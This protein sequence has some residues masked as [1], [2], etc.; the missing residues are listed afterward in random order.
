MVNN[1]QLVSIDLKPESIRDIENFVDTV[2]DQLFINETYYGNILM[3]LSELFNY[4]LDRKYTEAI[5][6]TYN[7]DYKSI[8]IS[9]Q[10]IDNQSI[11]K[12]S[13]A[14]DFE[15]IMHNDEDKN[16]FLI[17]SLVD[18]ISILDKNTLLFEFDISAMHNEIYKQRS[19]LLLNYFKK[20][21][22]AEKVRKEND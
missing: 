7:S 5:Y 13:G 19:E 3:S 12:F 1:N 17:H 8:G 20:Q 4:L 6:I 9:L 21:T 22:I 16:L 18:N 15:K 14:V 2:C 11:E 10:P